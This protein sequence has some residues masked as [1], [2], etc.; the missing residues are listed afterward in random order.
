MPVPR[1][2]EPLCLTGAVVLEGRRGVLRRKGPGSSWRP[3]ECTWCGKPITDK[4]RSKWCSQRCVDAFNI[5]QP[6]GQ[7][8]AL[9]ARD[10][11]WCSLCGLDTERLRAACSRW[12]RVWG[13]DRLATPRN[14]QH[15][16]AGL[17]LYPRRSGAG[18]DLA[19]TLTL[20]GLPTSERS[21]RHLLGT[22]RCWW[23]GDHTI[24]I[25]DGG[26]PCDMRNLR[27][28]CYW[29]HQRETSEAATRRAEQRRMGREPAPEP[30]TAQVALFATE[31][32]SC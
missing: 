4:R 3:G 21:I 12:L 14:P 22:R 7:L 29:C 17:S 23:D 9:E 24:P 27:T 31:A 32:P 8:A 1:Q 5:T 20:R 13:V 28:L 6:H 16:R 25:A 19:R 30:P 15:I 18:L 10:H 2:G 11:G 26:H